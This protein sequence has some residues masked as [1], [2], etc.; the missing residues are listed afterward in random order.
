MVCLHVGLKRNSAG[1]P[2]LQPH[3]V[4][5]VREQIPIVV[6]IVEM[7]RRHFTRAF[8]PISFSLISVGT[9]YSAQAPCYGINPKTPIWKRSGSFNR[10]MA[11]LSYRVSK[12]YS[13]SKE[14]GCL[15][16]SQFDN[17]TYAQ[18]ACKPHTTCHPPGKKEA[19]QHKQTLSMHSVSRWC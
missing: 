14:E 3:K 10:R 16:T 12:G 5:K 11:S 8:Y 13:I 9:W 15:Q 2:T 1:T 4:M 19:K 17:L 7:K 18:T 6:G